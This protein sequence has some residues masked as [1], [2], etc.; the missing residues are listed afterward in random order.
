MYIYIYIYIIYIYICVYV[1]GH[2]YMCNSGIIKCKRK[3]IAQCG[4]YLFKLSNKD[5]IATS[6]KFLCCLCC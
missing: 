5:V 6:L 1:Y 3:P 2:I 4:I